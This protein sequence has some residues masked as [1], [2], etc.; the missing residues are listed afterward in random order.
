LRLLL[1]IAIG[2][3]TFGVAQLGLSLASSRA[4]GAPAGWATTVGLAASALGLL[5]LG[6]LLVRQQRASWI[7]EQQIASLTA[8]EAR[9]RLLIE[10]VPDY[11]L[12]ALDPAGCV[13][14]W[15]SGAE[16]I[17]GY[18][19][20]EVTGRH[21][22]I[23]YP[24]EEVRVGKPAR[25]L[26]IATER[27]RI[28]DE[29]WRVRKD[30]T[31]F[32]ANVIVTALRNP[33][34]ELVGFAKI[35]RDVS[36]RKRLEQTLAQARDEALQASQLKSEFLATM[37]HEVRTPMNGVIGMTGLLME[38][39]LTAEQRTMGRVIQNSA[40]SLLAIIDDILDFSKIEA[41]KLRLVPADFELRQIVEET[42]ALLA[43]R[44]HE[45]RLELVCDFDGALTAPLVGDAG[46]IRQVLTNLVGNA[47]KFTERGEVG[48]SVQHLRDREGRTAF[49]VAVC[50]TGVGIPE[51]ARQRLFRPFTQ[52][53]GTATRRFGGTGLG[54]A[55][56]RQL[57]E[58]MAGNLGYESVPGQ[59]ATFWFELELPRSDAAISEPLAALPAGLRL[60]AVDDNA[61]NRRI[62]TSQLA[63]FG[64][65]AETVDNAPAALALMQA[66]ASEGMPFHLVLLDWHMPDVSGLQLAAQ[67]R[68][69]A[70]LART[71][72]VMLSS[73]GPLD[74]PMTAAS[75]GF[76]AFLVKP[77][78]QAQLHRCLARVLASVETLGAVVAATPAVNPAAGEAGL[79][80]LLVEDNLANQ[81]VARM[82]FEKMGHAVTVANNGREAL[83]Q[84]GQR[85]FD[86]VIMDCQMPEMDGYEAT[87]RIRSGKEP[88]IDPTIPVIAVTAHAL[89]EDRQKC[90]NA[91]MDDYVT[92]PVRAAALREAFLRCGL[93]RKAGA[94]PVRV[95][96]RTGEG[97][98]PL[99][100]ASRNAGLLT[101]TVASLAKT[102]SAALR[103]ILVVDDSPNDI[104]LLRERL[105]SAGVRNPIV[106]FT[107]SQE[108]MDFLARTCLEP[109]TPPAAAPCLV[110]LDIVM[111]GMD[112]LQML[113]WLRSREAFK[114]LRIVM[115]SSILNP[116]EI[117]RA[118]ELGADQ[119]LVKYP[120]ADMLAVIVADTLRP[121]STGGRPRRPQAENRSAS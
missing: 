30:G 99:P 9:S 45:K 80:L 59:G 76:A 91:G 63:H 117:E 8:S 121:D 67:I 29:G 75:I 26:A 33:A 110:F 69:D 101:S 119:Y 56:C 86:A 18:T 4:A 118:Y 115:V 22:A 65:A 74:D 42:V 37:S 64:L 72:L 92:K 81:M 7:A 35:A 28:E 82:L 66:R 20:D 3:G 113:G 44:A 97:G 40:E 94:P 107:G 53:D 68:A 62:L 100:S 32:W 10:N 108:A 34:G 47:I 5:L 88:G 24:A 85:A 98:P 48:V 14:T 31:R 25:D 104:A 71:P 58:L 38:T 6:A 39:A 87:R 70:G 49:R 112:G 73:A 79:R 55:I 19:T 109:G 83:A 16:R 114:S 103:P 90:L 21:C 12:F 102:E 77:V 89:P 36:E 96:A 23:F 13:T 116:T 54:L 120:V 1:P 105:D 43:P 52:A 93:L 57:I 106:A 17:H 46:R 61:T 50:D 60:L 27:G 15:N 95:R 2:V 78:R 111:P 11:A 84:L 51:E 41:G